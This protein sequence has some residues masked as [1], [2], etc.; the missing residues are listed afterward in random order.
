MEN[1]LMQQPSHIR[2]VGGI[3]Q[4]LQ[5]P[6]KLLSLGSRKESDVERA[7]NVYR[8]EDCSRLCRQK[9]GCR[10]WTWYNRYSGDLAL[11]CETMIDANV[12]TKYPGAISGERNC[13]SETTFP[14]GPQ[15]Q[16]PSRSERLTYSIGEVTF[17]S[18]TSW[19][20]CAQKCEESN[21][22][23]LWSWFDR[24][25]S[26]ADETNRKK[27]IEREKHDCQTYSSAVGSEIW[28][29]I[30]SGDRSCPHKGV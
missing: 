25:M 12:V 17:R 28:N 19:E 16:C 27:K 18:V 1:A 3:K 7:R 6:E 4:Q 13:G 26:I 5:C 21:N 11:I 8:W 9:V 14:N 24:K 23:Q 20:D 10:Y 2:F 29:G 22:C 30:I 15:L